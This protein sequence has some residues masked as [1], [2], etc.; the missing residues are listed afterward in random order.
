LNGSNLD[1][2][3]YT[4]VN[5]VNI[6]LAVGA[7][8]SDIVEVVSFTLGNFIESPQGTQ[9]GQGIQGPL[10][11]FQGTQGTQ[12]RQGRQGTQGRQG[13]QGPIGPGNDASRIDA[14]NTTLNST[15]YPVFVGGTGL[16]SPNIRNTATAF[17]YNAGTGELISNGPIEAGRGTGSVALT[18]NDG[19]GNANVAFN[20][21][22]G[23]PDVSGSSGRI[24]CDVDSTT[25][26]MSF[27]LG[28]NTVAATP[29]GLTAVLT[30][31]TTNAT[32]SGTVTA[33]SDESIKTN[34]HPIEN[35][36][37]KVLQ[38]RGVEFNY[39]EHGTKSIGVIAQEIEKIFP[40]LV[41]GDE[42]KSVAYQNLVAVLIEAIKELYDKYEKVLK[43]YNE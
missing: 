21:K 24:V 29:V 2:S 42:I 7:S 8:V 10:S 19:Y 30:M 15:F 34:I 41:Y 1:T 20:H 23:T 6:V 16:Q 31:S 26:G 33:N 32:F 9:G 40:E 43:I 12:G 18:L 14:S 4:A 25:A 35:A 27:Q 37:E 39:K 3:E 36:L 38:L 28:S 5:G 22:A 13:V 17:S 11:N